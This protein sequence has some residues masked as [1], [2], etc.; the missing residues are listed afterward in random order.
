[1]KENVVTSLEQLRQ[2]KEKAARQVDY[3]YRR[4]RNDVEDVF[5][6]R[7]RS[8]QSPASKYLSYIGYAVTAYKIATTVMGV[9]RMFRRKK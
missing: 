2:E 7:G 5:Y 4:L 8:M 9:V 6:S 3:G 1:M